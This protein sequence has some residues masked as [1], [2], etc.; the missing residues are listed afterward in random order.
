M[1]RSKET[2]R[3]KGTTEGNKKTMGKSKAV[4]KASAARDGSRGRTGGSPMG[5]FKRIGVVLG[6]LVVLAAVGLYAGSV[7]MINS[8][9]GHRVERFEITPDKLGLKAQE[10]S[11]VSSDGIPLSA[12]WAPV[13]HTHTKAIV[14]LLHG[15]E[16]M[17]ASSMLGHAKFLND[18]GYASLCLDMRAH[19]KS[20]GNRIGLAFEEPR[21]VFAALDWLRKRPEAED[22]PLVLLGVSMGGAVAIRTAAVRQDVDAVISVSSFASVD[23]MIQGFM[24]MMGAPR[25]LIASMPPF[26]QL[27]IRTVYGVWP[28]VASPLHDIGKI[29]PRPILLIHGT[30]DDQVPLD[31]VRLLEKAAS[32]KAQRVE[33]WIAQGGGHCVFQTIELTKPQDQEYTQRILDFLERLTGGQI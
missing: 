33:V 17:D 29:P 15:M 23:R 5:L 3:G 20:G 4:V 6:V 11:F 10:V 22:K 24:G 32:G 19:G 13:E 30:A 14:I 28:T 27:A 18:A 12:W 1:E 16:G 9:F 31:H 7:F 26:I 2:M 8:I 21:D 25:I